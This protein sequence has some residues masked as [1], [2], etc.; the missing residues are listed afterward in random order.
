[1]KSVTERASAYLARMPASIS[2]QKGD[3][4]AFSAAVALVRG[5][6]LSEQEALPLLSLWNKDCLPPW[7][8]KDLR[9]KLSCAAKSTKVPAGCLL[10]AER[11]RRGQSTRGA[12]SGNRTCRP[13]RPSK[14][15]STS[16]STPPSTAQPKAGA[17]PAAPAED[18]AWLRAAWP[19]FHP[20]THADIRA[21][22]ELR[23]IL[24]D[25]VDL[26]QR[27]GFVRVA[28]VQ[29]HRCLVITEGTFAQVRRL[30]G[31]PL[32]K[33]DGTRIKARNLSGSQGA[34]I[35]QR[36]LGETTHV[37]LVEGA[38]GLIEGLAAMLLV[39][40]PH[41]WSILAATSASSRFARDSALLERLRGKEVHIIPDADEAG[42]DAASSWLADLQSAGLYAIARLL[43]K[44]LKDLGDVLHLPEADRQHILDGLFITRK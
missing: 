28:E 22:A 27:H 20:L 3:A 19:E 36:W 21:V 35:G 1:M 11:P 8:E 37:L 5:F 6:D 2:G 39:D 18:R 15:C 34:F 9:Y 31:Q 13:D 42:M 12:K 40:T 16:Q 32:V 29:G 44:P 23:G 14:T 7:R 41:A 38:I 4:A 43:P 25:A 26:A 10:K 30:D 33:A 17:T 24:P